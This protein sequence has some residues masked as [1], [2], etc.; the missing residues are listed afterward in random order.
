MKKK[1]II[2]TA[3]TLA[4]LLLSLIIV[5]FKTKE[6]ESVSDQLAKVCNLEKILKNGELNV[7]VDNNS[8][9]YFVYKGRPMG[10]QYEMLLA[11]A[12]EMGVELNIT[13]STDM[14]KALSDLNHGVY[15]IVAKNFVVT[16]EKAE[17]IDFTEPIMLTRQVLIQRKSTNNEM[18]KISD[19]LDLANKTIVVQKNSVFAQR[20]HNLSEEI[21]EPIHVLEDSLSTVEQLI[22]QVSNG[23]IDYTVC[24]ENLA[25]A[26]AKLLTNIDIT[27][28]VSFNQKI[29]WAISKNSDNWKEYLDE[30]ITSYKNSR[31]YERI[32]DRYYGKI[33]LE[34]TRN[35]EFHSVL[36]GK[37]SIYD[38][39]IRELSKKY[40]LD[41]RL[42]SAVVI[43]ESGFDSEAESWMGACGLMQLMPQTAEIYGV[44]DILDPRQNVKAGI[45]HLKWLDS[46]LAKE[47]SDPE[48]RLK[49]TLAAYNV[50]LGHV[51]DARRLAKKHGK[52]EN[53]WTGNVD[54][55]ML[56]K[57]K[58]EFYTD[59][60]VRH[61]YCN[62]V[63]PVEYV[64]KVMGNYDHYLN[65]IPEHIE[66]EIDNQTALRALK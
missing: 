23:T 59:P 16:K 40:G 37:I 64:N 36:G 4:T 46:L 55:Y 41:W 32:V 31:N 2:A 7:I 56:N 58:Q 8:I 10:F 13:V 28:P 53:I 1:R 52:N 19:L 27:I 9:N 63:E 3:A 38:D 48:N 42:V 60:V 33:P 29:C 39:L 49:F 18:Y 26:N 51:L 11:L 57:S 45:L 6:P 34:Y 24:N 20:L 65:L 47:I 54:F 5:G 61:G 66:S 21:G 14:D 30:W 15:D 35:Q 17:M 12:N 43:Q 25:K 50:G 44:D 22:E 62:G